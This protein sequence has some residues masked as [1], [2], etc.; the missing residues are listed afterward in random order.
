MTKREILLQKAK[1]STRQ[2]VL[3]AGGDWLDVGMR[4]LSYEIYW[5]DDT[6]LLLQDKPCG[7]PKGDKQMTIEDTPAGV[8]ITRTFPKGTPICPGEFKYEK[9]TTHDTVDIRRFS[10]HEEVDKASA[11][12]LPPNVIKAAMAAKATHLSPDG[13]F[14]YTTKRLD[15]HWADGTS[16]ARWHDTEGK[17]GHWWR[18]PDGLPADAV[19]ISSLKN[20]KP[21]Q[22]TM[23]LPL[24]HSTKEPQ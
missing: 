23:D 24:A 12:Q 14:A 8:V 11:L 4:P 19:E 5:G 22:M 20:G 18:L 3:G 9:F 10:Q 6:D 13:K 17:F 15:V 1:T 16:S 21:E 7:S 2:E